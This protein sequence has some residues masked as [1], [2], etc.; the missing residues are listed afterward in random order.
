MN[1]TLLTGSP[2]GTVGFTSENGWI[3]NE[4]F[5]MWLQHFSKYNKPSKDEPVILILDGY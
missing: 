4:L 2:P 1:N 3:N 5:I